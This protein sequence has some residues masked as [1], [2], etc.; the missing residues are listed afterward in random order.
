MIDNVKELCNLKSKFLS[1]PYL[2]LHK[3]FNTLRLFTAFAFVSEMCFP[4]SI[5][6]QTTFQEISHFL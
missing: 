5:L 3:I 1:E 4:N 6:Y 2:L